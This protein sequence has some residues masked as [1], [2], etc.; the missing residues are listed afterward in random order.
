[1]KK[2]YFFIGF[3]LFLFLLT[4]KFAT[5]QI[6][7]G[8]TSSGGVFNKGVLFKYTPT[9][10]FKAVMDFGNSGSTQ[11]SVASLPN[12]NLVQAQNGFIYGLSIWGGT[13][14]A[15]SIFA[16]DPLMDT[17]GV[18]HSFDWNDGS[19]PESGLIQV[20]NGMIYGTAQMGG[21]NYDGTIFSFNPNTGVFTLLNSFSQFTGSSPHNRLV[22]HSNNKLY[23]VTIQGGNN[24][25]GTIFS[26]DTAT[27]TLTA[28]VHIDTTK[29]YSVNGAL[30]EA[31]NAK[32]Y[33]TAKL[34]GSNSQGTIFEYD[35]STSSYVA[36]ISFN[37][38]NGSK[39]EGGLTC[40]NGKLYGTTTFGGSF[41]E[42]VIFEYD[43][44]NGTIA[45]KYDF[46]GS[47]SGRYPKGEMIVGNDQKL[48]GATSSGGAFGL[49]IFFRFDPVNGNLVKLFD[50]DSINGMNP[51]SI[52]GIQTSE[53]Q[54]TASDS[55]FT[56][57][58]FNIQFTNQTPN[59]GKY[60]WQWQ[61]GDG[62][63]SYQTSPSHTYTNNGSFHITLIGYDTINHTQDT[64]VRH[65]YID[66]S[67]ATPCPVTAGLYPSSII[68]LC[69]GDSILL[70]ST[71][72]DAGNSYQWLRSGI[73]LSGATD[74][75]YWAK[76]PGYYQVRVDNGSCWNFSNFAFIMQF[77][78]KPP[79]VKK[80]GQLQPCTDDSMQL[81]VKGTYSNYL[82]STGETTPS[83]WVK[84]S[85][86]YTV[87]VSDNN[88]CSVTSI[89]DTIN[90]ALINAPNICIVGVDSVTGKNMI[91][92]NQSSLLELDSVRV[93]KETTVNNVFQLIGSKART[94]TGLLI[95]Q[96][97]DPRV[98]SYR[99][100]LMAIDSCGTATPIGNFHRTIH[101]QVNVGM[102]GTWNL[103]WNPYEGASLG[104]YHIYRGTDSTQMSLVTS[105]PASIHSFTDLNPP[106]GDVY[107]LL[108]IDLNNA[109]SP[110]GGTTF[111]MSSSNFFNTKD[112][113]ISTI[114]I[115]THDISLSVFPNPNNGVFTLKMSSENL[116]RVHISIFNNLG[117]MVASEQ[118]D[119]NGTIN[120]NLN[121]SHLSKGIYFIRMQ[122]SNDVAV[123]KVI[124]Q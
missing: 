58:P 78:T 51:A 11:M 81:Q 23:G 118:I 30:C 55:I 67:G 40:F 96:N 32:L 104:S 73:S 57:P 7:Y 38:G 97:S 106:S 102:N 121:L 95:D 49:G 76:Q 12:G 13:Q 119:V 59:S 79:V 62:A 26:L 4:N 2:N 65:H 25:K 41:N 115:T 6:I 44:A 15:G 61:F 100:Q 19:E 101:L 54:F 20:S 37:G 10:N 93:Y 80:I 89:I 85:G 50:F 111:N 22:M 94:E 90:A 63:V 3:M 29:G 70:H 114:E 117:S 46:N 116:Q 107:Y 16:F 69:P 47:V 71:N 82:W 92:W 68:T 35:P 109:C 108:K 98:T 99:Y 120:K 60:V 123:R 103:H 21:A 77:P 36:K 27:N 18:V 105:L 86:L 45:K 17:M 43:V 14:G 91:V 113:T 64:L 34:G 9:P 52:G 122:T 24:G 53:L 66:L 75:V 112:A 56:A 31:S 8:V 28:A 1:M 88:S 48:Y 5:A 83:I 42:G 33:G 72:Q 74:T 110:G 84:N 87:E 124:I 39:P